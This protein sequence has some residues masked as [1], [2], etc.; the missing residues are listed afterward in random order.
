MQ[1]VRALLTA[2]ER[3]IM[4]VGGAGWNAQARE[5]IQAFAE[6]NHLAVG[7]SFR[8]QDLF[9]NSSPCYA[10]TLGLGINPCLVKRIEQA[11]LVI[12]AGTRPDALSTGQYHLLDIPRPKQRLI[13]IYPDVEEL[14]RV[15]QADQYINAG[16]P[17][18]AVAARV[19]EP[20]EEPPWK[21]WTRQSHDDLLACL[22][23]RPRPARLD[24]GQV[25]TYLRQRLP[26]DSIL[27][28]GAGNYTVWC[29]RYYSFSAYP[30]Q[31]APQSGVMGYGLPAAIAAKAVHPDRFAVAFAGDGCFLMN[32]Q[33]LA[34]AVQYRLNII[35]LVI[36]NNM[37]GTIRAHQERRYP[38]RTIGTSLVNPDF[39]AYAEAFGAYG[40]V[41]NRTEGFPD[42]FERAVAAGR[43]AVIELRVEAEESM[44]PSPMSGCSWAPRP[45]LLVPNQLE[46]QDWSPATSE[47]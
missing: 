37:Y 36:N 25:M 40:E 41:V 17:Q 30:T 24:L 21:E 28:N 14:G 46:S 32:G 45:G 38:G 13:H 27:S 42:A 39:A 26:Q 12:L 9:D 3:P 20:I 29:H 1:A 8:R 31:L 18:F 35:V 4:I 43:P 33:E 23:W 5:D 16:M 22:A 11:D 10:G 7:T 47:S 44:A 34:T 15:Y 19:L 2:A 6:A